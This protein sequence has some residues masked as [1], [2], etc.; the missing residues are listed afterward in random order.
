M[1]VGH[2]HIF[3]VIYVCLIRVLFDIGG[4]DE[5][6]MKEGS[7][8]HIHINIIRSMYAVCIYNVYIYILMYIR[9]KSDVYIY[10]YVV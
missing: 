7:L 3:G 6:K 1:V 10:M 5:E 4:T 8:F 2:I 9:I